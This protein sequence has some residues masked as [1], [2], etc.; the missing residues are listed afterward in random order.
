MI[1]DDRPSNLSDPTVRRCAASPSLSL[2]LSRSLFVVDH[3]RPPQLIDP[4]RNM[5][6]IVVTKYILLREFCAPPSPRVEERAATSRR[7]FQPCK[8]ESGLSY[9]IRAFAARFY[10]GRPATAP[11]AWPACQ[12]HHSRA[13]RTHLLLFKTARAAN[14]I[15]S[16]A[17]L[18]RR[19]AQ[20]EYVKKVIRVL[21]DTC[22]GCAPSEILS[23]LQPDMSTQT[24]G[25]AGSS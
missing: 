16:H 25:S 17:A 18:V 21:G 6:H 20:E 22:L 15:T 19:P 7:R 1:G 9:V 8:C 12:C 2:S 4:G 24:K 5:S 14:V 11:P 13:S 3:A 10:R 23:T